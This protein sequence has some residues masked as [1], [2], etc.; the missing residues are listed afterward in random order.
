MAH[1]SLKRSKN[2][3]IVADPENGSDRVYRSMGFGGGEIS[4]QLSR[5]VP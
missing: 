2:L 4:V 5:R 3:V 1:R